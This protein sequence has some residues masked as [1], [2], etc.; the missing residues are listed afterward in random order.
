MEKNQSFKMYIQ[1]YILNLYFY[2]ERDTRV[3]TSFHSL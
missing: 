2:S 1:I 3:K